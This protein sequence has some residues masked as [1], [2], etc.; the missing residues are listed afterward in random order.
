MQQKQGRNFESLA[1]EFTSHCKIFSITSLNFGFH[2][3]NRMYF[4]HLIE[5]HFESLR[6]DSLYNI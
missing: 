4:W 2:H 6:V 1:F 5:S 3:F